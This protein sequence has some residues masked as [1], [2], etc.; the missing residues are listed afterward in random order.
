[1]RSSSTLPQR[2]AKANAATAAGAANNEFRPYRGADVVWP[3]RHVL[4]KCNIMLDHPEGDLF[5]TRRIALD[6]ER[7]E[8]AR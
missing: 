4:W 2:D 1:M 5:D 8:R 7:A 3:G 6:A